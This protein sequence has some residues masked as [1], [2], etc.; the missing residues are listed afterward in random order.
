MKNR[1]AQLKTETLLKCGSG[2][3]KAQSLTEIRNET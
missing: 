3:I 1:N 2:A